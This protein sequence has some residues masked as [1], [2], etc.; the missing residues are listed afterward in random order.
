[1]SDQQYAVVNALWQS[2]PPI[3]RPEAA[4]AARKLRAHFR[5]RP[6]EYVRRCWISLQG[7]R[8]D[9]GWHRLVH[10]LSHTH[11]RREYRTLRPHGPHHAKIEREMVEYVL[12]QGWLEGTLR[13]K[14]PQRQP[15][16]RPAH[17][18]AMLARWQTRL[19][20]ATTMV[21]K[22]RKRVRYYERRAA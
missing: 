21:R 12:S 16:D 1:M 7:G 5:M 9:K 2:Y 14:P 17:A 8:S 11:S 20:R 10:D 22:W 4:R 3:T 13:P 6:S 18:A 19:K 15:A